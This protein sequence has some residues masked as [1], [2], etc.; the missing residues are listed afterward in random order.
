MKVSTHVLV[1]YASK[2]GATAEIAG[3]IALTLRSAGLRADVVPAG[4][5]HDLGPYTAVVLGSAVYMGGWRREAARFLKRFEPELS[6]RPVWLFSSGPTG[7]GDPVALVHGRRV[8]DGLKA[9]VACI[10]PRDVTVFH[11]RLD[12]ETLGRI[13]R[14]VVTRVAAPSG[15]FR[16]AAA[17]RDWAQGIANELTPA[18][19]T[20]A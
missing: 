14:W 11:G 15:D 20:P 9:L 8:P 6:E 19:P 17:I 1:A 18:V 5:V 2:H 16:D 4:D 10:E 13:E 7:L 12:P 3:H